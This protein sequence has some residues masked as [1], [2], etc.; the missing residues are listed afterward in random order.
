MTSKKLRASQNEARKSKRWCY[1]L[2]PKFYTVGVD[3]VVRRPF[4]IRESKAEIKAK[5]R[6][7]HIRGFYAKQ[8][9][10]SV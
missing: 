5:K 1:G 7:T 3:G 10:A 2:N 4:K 9:G 6:S 8:R